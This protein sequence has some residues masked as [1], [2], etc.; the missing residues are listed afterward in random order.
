M[1]KNKSFISSI[2]HAMKGFYDAL[3]REKNLRFHVIIGNLICFFAV[4]FGITRIEWGLLL[5]TI[6]MVITCEVINSAIEKTVDTATHNMRAD[7]MHA[8]DFAAAATLVTAIIAV[9]VGIVLFADPEKIVNA[10]V[11]I[12]T[13]PVSLI[14]LGILTFINIKI[15]LINTRRNYERKKF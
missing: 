7:A 10:L 14:I 9:L 8:K 2:R 4:H 1:L 6:C 13:S 3:K 12:F 15:I 5:I 11:S